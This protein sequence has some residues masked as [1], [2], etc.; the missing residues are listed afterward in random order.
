MKLVLDH[1]KIVETKDLFGK[2]FHMAVLDSFRAISSRF[3][4][5]G[6]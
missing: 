1:G 3:Q 5:D 6:H 2:V 4:G